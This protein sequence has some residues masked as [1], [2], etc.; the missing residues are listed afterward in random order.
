MHEAAHRVAGRAVLAARD[1][2]PVD[3]PTLIIWGEQDI[4]QG[5][6]CLDGIQRYVRDAKS[7]SKN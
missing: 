1:V 5:L 2:A 3:T 7:L 6:P 4:A